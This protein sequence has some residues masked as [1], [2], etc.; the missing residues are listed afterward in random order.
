MATPNHK[1]ANFDI[2]GDAEPSDEFMACL[3]RILLA[4]VDANENAAVGNDD[5]PPTANAKCSDDDDTTF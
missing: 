3:A 4:A 2:V 5:D 1:P